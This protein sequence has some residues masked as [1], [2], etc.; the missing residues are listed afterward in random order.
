MTSDAGAPGEP[1]TDRPSTPRT[2]RR[3]VAALIT[4][5]LALVFAFVPIVNLIAFIP[6]VLAI[7]LG[8][9]AIRDGKDDPLLKGRRMAITAVVLG[10]LVVLYTLTVLYV[11][12]FVIGF[13]E[14][15]DELRQASLTALT[16]LE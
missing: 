8:S 14:F 11:L 4:G 2:S 7:V 3:A 1:D 6:A 10:V 13:D 15:M 16:L 9:R 12:F 5:L